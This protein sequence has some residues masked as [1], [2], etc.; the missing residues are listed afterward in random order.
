M[1]VSAFKKWIQ[2][3]LILSSKG[4]RFK[5]IRYDNFESALISPLITLCY[6]KWFLSSII[7]VS[8]Y[9]LPSEYWLLGSSSNIIS[10][11]RVPIQIQS[12]DANNRDP[13]EKLPSAEVQAKLFRSKVFFDRLDLKWLI[14][15][16]LPII[17]GWNTW[18]WKHVTRIN[19]RLR[20]VMKS[21]RISND[22]FWT[23][24]S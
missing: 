13:R 19:T 22:Y 12:K 18:Y 3:K 6:F 4:F 14:N 16:R 7:L 20:L 9:P 1:A 2:V 11:I 17:Y 24:M 21:Y 23:I 10:S 8:F 15:E 5:I